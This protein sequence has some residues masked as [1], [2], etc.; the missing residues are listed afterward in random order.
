MTCSELST[1]SGTNLEAGPWMEPIM[2]W[3]QQWQRMEPNGSRLG[4]LGGRRRRVHVVLHG[5]LPA[6][7]CCPQGLAPAEI[8]AICEKRNFNVAHGL[9]WSYYI[10]Y[11]RLIL[12]GEPS[13]LP[14]FPD[15][16]DRQ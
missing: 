16:Q 3:V 12:P 1:G 4:N 7:P 2:V 5:G 13:S 8:S 14:P 15:L 6:P 10:G 11:L 9:A